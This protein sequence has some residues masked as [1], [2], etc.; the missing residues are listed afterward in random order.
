MDQNRPR[1]E[2]LIA[3][4]ARSQIVVPRPAP[5]LP[6]SSLRAGSLP[7]ASLPAASLPAASLPTGFDRVDAVIL[8]WIAGEGRRIGRGFALM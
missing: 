5:T 2:R 4:V 1:L 7:A 8:D 3:L 6:A